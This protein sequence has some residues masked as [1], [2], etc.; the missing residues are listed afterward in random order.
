MTR[1]LEEEMQLRR[2]QRERYFEDPAHWRWSDH[3]SITSPSLYQDIRDDIFFEYYILNK[4]GNRKLSDIRKQLDNGRKLPINWQA[5]YD[6]FDE[7]L[8]DPENPT[9]HNLLVF[10]FKDY[11]TNETATVQEL[12]DD[13]RETLLGLDFDVI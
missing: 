1:T 6:Y 4:R 8:N 10:R 2:K 3:P 12:L 13:Y 11:E 7:R 5:F 9:R